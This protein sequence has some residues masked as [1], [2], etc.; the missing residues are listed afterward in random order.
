MLTCVKKVYE[1]LDWL[2]AEF[3]VNDNFWADPNVDQ[4]QDAAQHRARTQHTLNK[5]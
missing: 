3:C 5:I 1:R 2:V 4:P